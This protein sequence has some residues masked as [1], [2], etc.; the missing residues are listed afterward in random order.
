MT[1]KKKSMTTEKIVRQRRTG[2]PLQF[3]ASDEFIEAIDRWR[4]QQPG[5]PGRSE[6]IRRLVEQAL[7]AESPAK[8]PRK[9]KGT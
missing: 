6:A 2:R 4:G 3:Y 9:K 8:P 5:V 1:V 7:G